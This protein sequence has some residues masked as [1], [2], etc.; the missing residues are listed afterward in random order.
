M[1]FLVYVVFRRSNGRGFL[2]IRNISEMLKKGEGRGEKSE[3]R[4]EKAEGAT[5]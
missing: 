4:S 3:G 5:T 2:E 1:R